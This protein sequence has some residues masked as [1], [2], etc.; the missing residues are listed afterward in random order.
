MG[1]EVSLTPRVALYP[2]KR[3]GTHFTGG[4][5]GPIARLNRGGKGNLATT[6]IRYTDRLA[7]SQS[8]CRLS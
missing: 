2:R 1:W 8:L 4:A 7:R 5:V 6:G 3:H